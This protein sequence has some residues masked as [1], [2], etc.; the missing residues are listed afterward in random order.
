MKK[1]GVAQGVPEGLVEALTS[2]YQGEVE[3]VMSSSQNTGYEFVVT[4]DDLPV[5]PGAPVR[6]Y[7]THTDVVSLEWSVVAA[8]HLLPKALRRGIERPVV[9]PLPV[10]FKKN[11]S[12]DAATVA[13]LSGKWASEISVRLKSRGIDSEEVAGAGTS[14]LVIDASSEGSG[15]YRIRFPMAA[16]IPVVGFVSNPCARDTIRHQSN[17]LLGSNAE[18]IVLLTSELLKNKPELKRLGFEARA[19]LAEASWGRVARALLHKGRVGYPELEELGSAAKYH[20]WV[21]RLGH[22]AEWKDGHLVEN[23]EGL[24]MRQTN[25]GR[26]ISLKMREGLRKKMLERLIGEADSN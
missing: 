5:P 25:G 1:I 9:A 2:S 10:E 3:Q 17:G 18:E 14:S 8:R 21:E 15:V 22:A 26:Q 13:V 7:V 11:C 16:E 12:R 24:A 6:R 19:T 4:C 23:V 20:R